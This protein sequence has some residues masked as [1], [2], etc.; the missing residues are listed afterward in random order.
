M[1]SRFIS[2]SLSN[3][4]IDLDKQYTQEQKDEVYMVK[5]CPKIYLNLD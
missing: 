3:G 2:V 5:H 4:A 1:N